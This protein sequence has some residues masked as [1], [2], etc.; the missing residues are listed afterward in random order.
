M[1]EKIENPSQFRTLASKSGGG[2][3]NTPLID[4]FD[5]CF[6]A[7][8]LKIA[9]EQAAFGYDGPVAFGY[10][11]IKDEEGYKADIAEKAAAL[12]STINL[13][14]QDQLIEAVKKCLWARQNLIEQEH[15]I[16]A[17]EQ[18]ERNRATA[19]GILRSIYTSG[20]DDERVA[21]EAASQFFKKGRKDYYDVISYLF[22]LKNSTRFVH[23]RPH[24]CG[25]RLQMLGYKTT[26]TLKCSWENYQEYL[27]I[28]REV[29]ERL[30]EREI[31]NV[32]LIDAQ[33]FVWMLWK[34]E[35]KPIKATED[36]LPTDPLVTRVIA[37]GKEGGKIQYY[38]TKYER[39]PRL[40]KAC[41]A[42]KGYQCEVCGFR[43]TDDYGVIGKD[44]IEVHHKKPL[45]TLD[46]EAEVDPR[47]DLACLCSNCHRMIHRKKN[48]VYTVEYLREIVEEHR[49]LNG[50]TL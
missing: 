43:F 35:G 38:T 41:I 36:P 29:Q 19:F 17:I 3:V 33:T 44:F 25:R 22:F 13:N 23:L 34:I 12:L 24:A 26:C 4:T 14:D 40:R 50:G 28:M 32:S 27:R 20:P 49:K 10:G 11:V 48:A 39:D 16:E 18:I 2:G 9:S 47:T 31:E 37:K 15:V 30:S 46:G 6:K 42:L 5:E 45:S 8:W 21:F 7:L 1:G